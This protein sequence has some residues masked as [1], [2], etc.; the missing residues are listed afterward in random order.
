MENFDTRNFDE[1]NFDK[2]I[3][4]FMGEEEINRENLDGLLTIRQSFLLSN[5]C[6]IQ[7]INCLIWLRTKPCFVS[8]RMLVFWQLMML[9]VFFCMISM[10]VS[11]NG[12]CDGR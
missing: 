6:A 7:Y 8:R 3:V 9:A 5:F 11:N 12:S 4:G 10:T 2:L 1:Q